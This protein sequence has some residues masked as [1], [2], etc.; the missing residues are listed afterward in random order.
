MKSGGGGESLPEVGITYFYEM[1]K[2]GNSIKTEK[3]GS[4]DYRMDQKMRSHG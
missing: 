2:I 4:Q 1:F 3:L